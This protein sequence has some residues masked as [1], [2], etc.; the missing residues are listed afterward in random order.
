M[1]SQ[2]GRRYFGSSKYRLELAMG[3]TGSW[4]LTRARLSN[5]AF[6]TGHDYTQTSTPS[7]LVLG[8]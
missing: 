2:G 6:G 8:G 7:G 1:N 5:L 3:T 4:K